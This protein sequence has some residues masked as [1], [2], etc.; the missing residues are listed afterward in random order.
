MYRYVSPKQLYHVRTRG[1]VRAGLGG[2]TICAQSPSHPNLAVK[3][4]FEKSSVRFGSSWELHPRH[5][6]E[7]TN[8]MLAF[9]AK[10]LE[11]GD[12]VNHFVSELSPE[13]V[14]SLLK[15]LLV[16]ARDEAY[17][18]ESDKMFSK[19]DANKDGVLSKDEFLRLATAAAEESALP[20]EKP[21]YRQ[22]WALYAL[23]IIFLL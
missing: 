13:A 14:E 18:A 11:C 21:T 16:K 23:F 7:E 4:L 3:K 12:A 15:S 17:K 6:Q 22:A 5:G 10:K 1:F 20:V 9:A 8:T 2:P 19:L